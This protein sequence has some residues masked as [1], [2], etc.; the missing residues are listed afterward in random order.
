V[1]TESG[2]LKILHQ[3]IKIITQAFPHF[4]GEGHGGDGVAQQFSSPFVTAGRHEGFI[5]FDK[6]EIAKRSRDAE[7]RFIPGQN[8][9]TRAGIPH[10]GNAAPAWGTT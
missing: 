4:Q 5:A 7:N 9:V 6:S 1:Q 2:R 10:A 8:Q 3:L